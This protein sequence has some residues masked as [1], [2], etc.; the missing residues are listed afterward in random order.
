LD[1]IIEGIIQGIRLILTGDP[2]VLSI[3]VLSLFVSASGTLISCLWSIPVAVMLALRG[4]QGKRI[5]K[6]FFNALIGVPTVA[7]GLYLYLVLSRAGPL[8][9]FQFLYTPYGIIIGQCILVTPIIVSFTTSALES[10]DPDLR[11]LARTLGASGLQIDAVVLKEAFWGMMLAIIAAF[12]RAFAELGVAMMLGGNI[13]G[14][15]RV[16]TTAIALETAKGEIALSI[17]LS[18][19]LLG[20]VM[21]LSI[22]VNLARR[23]SR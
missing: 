10:V 19:I 13:R 17:A 12:N 1:P 22:I 16:L 7:L 14:L 4:F 2:E 15:T 11:M 20:I 8:G 18:F 3:T 5:V 9:Y 23:S 6:G 21:S